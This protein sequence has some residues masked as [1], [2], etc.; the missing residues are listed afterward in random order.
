MCMS[1]SVVGF[2]VPDL[3]SEEVLFSFIMLLQ[4]I[5]VSHHTAVGYMKLESVCLFFC[6]SVIQIG[7]SNIFNADNSLSMK[8]YISSTFANTNQV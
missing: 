2:F 5:Y 3:S 4:Q 7:L 1:F 6:T 8:V